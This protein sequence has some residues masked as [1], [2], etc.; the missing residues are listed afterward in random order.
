LTFAAAI[1]SIDDE[2]SSVAEACSVEPCDSC[3]AL[4]DNSWLPAET[5]CAAA[6][7]SET[8]ERSLST[9][10]SSAI[11]S[12]SLSDRRLASI[13]RL[14]FAISSAMAAVALRFFLWKSSARLGTSLA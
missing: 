4:A 7:A 10:R 12:V 8:M 2:A 5:F 6:I 14:P 1:S 11:P 9:M 13:V 3:S